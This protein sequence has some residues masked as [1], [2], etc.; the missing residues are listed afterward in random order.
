[1]P[2]A[3]GETIAAAIWYDDQQ[4]GLGEQFVKEIQA[5]LDKVR[6]NPLSAPRLEYYVGPHDIRRQLV[7]RFPYVVVYLC[8][9]DDIVVVAVAHSRRR[10]LHWLNRLN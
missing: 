5:A 7:S 8:R 10:P 2:E 6:R 4:S 1:L 3:D 9:A